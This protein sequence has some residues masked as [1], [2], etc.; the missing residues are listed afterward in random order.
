MMLG[1]LPFIPDQDD[2]WAVTADLMDAVPPGSYL[3]VSHGAS[4]IRAGEVAEAGRR[5]NQHSAVRLRL[6][7]RAEFARFF[8]GL[9][10]A[11]PGL[12]PVNHWRPP[13][14]GRQEEGLPAYAALG[15]KPVPAP[16]GSLKPNRLIWQ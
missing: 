12:V 2:P 10:L 6:R 9:E 13:P 15:R 14:G 3:A 7:T 4:D 5:Y 1:I 11:E 8:D 16:G